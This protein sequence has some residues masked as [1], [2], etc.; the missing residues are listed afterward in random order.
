MLLSIAGIVHHA[1]VHACSHLDR[2]SIL[3]YRHILTHRA[4]IIANSGLHVG[5][6]IEHIDPI[7]TCQW[8]LGDYAIFGRSSC[9]R[10]MKHSDGSDISIWSVASVGVGRRIKLCCIDSYLDGAEWERGTWE[11]VSSVVRCARN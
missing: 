11:N 7:K 9:A 5:Q 3:K 6:V 10:L 8:H 1:S 4:R 2:D